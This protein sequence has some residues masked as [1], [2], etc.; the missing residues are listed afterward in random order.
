MRER[1]QGKRRFRG[2]RTSTELLRNVDRSQIFVSA[3]VNGEMSEPRLWRD[4]FGCKEL[5]QY[6]GESVEEK[7]PKTLE[8]VDFE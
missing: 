1:A 2:R 4:K 7:D 8:N 6:A 5:P 3:L